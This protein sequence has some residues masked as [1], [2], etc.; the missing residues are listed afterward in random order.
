MATRVDTIVFDIGGVLVTWEPHLVW[1]RLLGDGADVDAFLDE[2]G[3]VEWNDSLDAGGD[4]DEATEELV[5]RFP[6]H[7][8]ALRAYREAYIDTVTGPVEGS[9]ELLHELRTAGIPLYALTNWSSEGMVRARDQ[10]TFLSLFLGVVVS[11]DEKLAKPDPR[12]WHLLAE[13]YS[14]VPERTLYVD[15]RPDNVAA[16]AALGFRAVQFTDAASLRSTLVD[17]GL[18]G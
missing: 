15:D 18:L 17:E 5:L 4:W 6:H 8:P 14:L 16:A 13:R 9:V 10:L 12:I 11:G 3:F 2:I 7:E 1:A